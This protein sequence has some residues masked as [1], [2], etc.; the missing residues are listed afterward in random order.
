MQQS[1]TSNQPNFKQHA[2]EVRQ[3][4]FI[5]LIGV[6]YVLLTAQPPENHMIQTILNFYFEFACTHALHYF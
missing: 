5:D 4:K 1:K 2:L 3:S 6:I